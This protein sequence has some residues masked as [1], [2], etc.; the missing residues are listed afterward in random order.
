MTDLLLRSV[1]GKTIHD[2][3]HGLVFWSL[4]VALLVVATLS[5]WPS[6]RDEYA[7][8]VENYPESLLALF[9]I[10]K[11]GIATAAGYVQAELFSFVVPLVFLGYAIAGGSGATAAEEEGGTLDLLLAQPVSRTKVVLQK[12]AG[13]LCAMAVIGA[14]T[15]AVLAVSC[16][17]F[18]LPVGVADL[19]AAT[20][21]AYLLGALF[22]A[23]A[24]A[25]GA[26]TG[27]R[28]LAAGVTSA[29]ALAAYLLVSLAGLVDGL[30]RFRPISPFWWYSG[31]NPLRYGVDPL[32]TVLLVAFTVV[33]TAAAVVAFRRRDLH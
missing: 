26:A 32:H 5:A 27:H 17:V 12:Y 18:D 29:V 22:G 21:A 23:A 25:L 4:G 16:T 33:A 9:G 19:A 31:N 3:R 30:K 13:V 6:V 14:V 15:L 20:L 8:L 7:Q 28:A 2:R 11:A 10:D 1:F 24:L